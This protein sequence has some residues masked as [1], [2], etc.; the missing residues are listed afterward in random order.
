MNTSKTRC[1]S[2]WVMNKDDENFLRKAAPI[3]VC[4]LILAIATVFL[5]ILAV[6]K[7]RKLE[8][9]PYGTRI[10]L[11]NLSGGNFITGCSLQPLIV[12]FLVLQIHGKTVCLVARICDIVGSVLWISSFLTLLAATY[13]RYISIFHPHFHWKLVVGRAL[14]IIVAVI[15]TCAISVVILIQVSIVIRYLWITWIFFNVVGCIW[16]IFA[17]TRIY[18]M[19][20]QVKRQIRAQGEQFKKRCKKRSVTTTAVLVTISIICYLPYVVILNINFFK[21]SIRLNSL[22]A[23]WL[24]MLLSATSVLNP[25][26]YCLMDK[27]LQQAIFR[28]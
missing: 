21:R 20:Y 14:K 8:N 12:V 16:I 19:A 18:C 26:I 7:L 1:V 11:L 15:W 23:H 13:E 2:F 4:T 28:V 10:L 3:V 17:Y 5:N 9:I 25:I 6:K 24:W 22:M 27:T